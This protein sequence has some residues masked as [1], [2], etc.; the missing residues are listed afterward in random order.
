MQK[1]HFLRLALYMNFSIVIV[2]GIFGLVRNEITFDMPALSW[3]YMLICAVFSM[4]LALSMFAVGAKEVG[5]LTS[6]V[7]STLE[8]ISS[9]ISGWL[10]LGESLT[11]VKLLGCVMII[12]SIIVILKAQEQSKTSNA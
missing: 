9:V 4:V 11:I 3:I 1:L 7:L 12:I 8:P 2:S 5:G 10:F 6:A